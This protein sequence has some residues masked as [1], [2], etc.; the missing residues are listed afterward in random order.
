MRWPKGAAS[1]LLGDA[2]GL[3]RRRERGPGHSHLGGRVR[4]TLCLPPVSWGLGDRRGGR[5]GLS[6]AFP[7]WRGC[8]Q[9]AHCEPGPTG[10]RGGPHSVWWE[11]PAGYNAQE[12]V[13]NGQWHLLIT[14]QASCVRA[15]SS[16]QAARLRALR[17]PWAVPPPTGPPRTTEPLEHRLLPAAVGLG[18][19]HSL[20]R[21]RNSPRPSLLR[22]SSGGEGPGLA[23]PPRPAPWGRPTRT[24]GLRSGGPAWIWPAGAD[25]AP[26]EPQL[27]DLGHLGR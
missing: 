24:P 15:A 5:R 19:S 7:R 18:G 13:T 22:T 10:G 21:L 4:I 26:R 3:L 11:Q 27:P 20:G 23:G 6:S 17:P 8:P 1:L 25:P 14:A 9:G 2:K 12:G 16:A